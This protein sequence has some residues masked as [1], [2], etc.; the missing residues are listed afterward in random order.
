MNY[1]YK[2]TIVLL[3][4]VGFLVITGAQPYDL[5][6]WMLEVA[7]IVFVIPVLWYTRKSFPLTNLLLILI[8]I[9]ALVLAIGAKYTYARVPLGFT[10]Q[11][12]FELNRNP[13][14]KIGHFFQGCVPA[15]VAREILI[16]GQYIRSSG[17]L[18]FI[19]VCVVLA[20]SATYEMIEWAAALVMGQGADEFLG[21][22][23]DMWDTQSD[24]FLAL[25]GALF[26][27]LMLSR[28]HNRQLAKLSNKP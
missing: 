25:I 26:T 17:M 14:D 1:N 3:L 18:N 12:L 5:L 27:L 20:V 2:L 7:P 4:L 11:E 19:V 28:L 22:Q 24:M 10:L 6:T 13:Y 8:V 23:G 9:H 16:R 21:T 15:L